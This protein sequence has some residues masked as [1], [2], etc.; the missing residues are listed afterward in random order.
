MKKIVKKI[1]ARTSVTYQCETCKTKYR[2]AEKAKECENRILEEKIFKIGDE[3]I[4]IPARACS[5]GRFNW[6]S[7]WPKATVVKI[8]GPMLPDYEY[9][10]K[11][12]DSRGL[13]SH[14]YQYEVEYACFCRREDKRGDLL[15]APEMFRFQ[16]KVPKS[17]KEAREMFKK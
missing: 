2:T 8:L 16:G 6:K 3:I 10:V 14:V 11:W 7:F 5:N 4:I 9:E 13:N 17:L 1:P 12:L 15:Y